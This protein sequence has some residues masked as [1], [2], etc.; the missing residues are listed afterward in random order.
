MEEAGGLATP[1]APLAWLAFEQFGDDGP[2][3]TLQL[4]PGGGERV[5]A[6]ADA[7]A[8]EVRWMD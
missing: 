7:H 2:R 1:E 6:V 4:W 8:R 3:L 5:L